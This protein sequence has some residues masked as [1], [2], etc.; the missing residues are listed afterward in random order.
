MKYNIWK[1][2]YFIDNLIDKMVE[3]Y[4]Y[5][6]INLIKFSKNCFMNWIFI[7]IVNLNNIYETLNN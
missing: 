1:L 2:K 5:R 4:Y 7:L 3:N 6:F